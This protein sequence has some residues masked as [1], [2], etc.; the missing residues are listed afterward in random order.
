MQRL[1]NMSI[2]QTLSES[3][4]NSTVY[5]STIAFHS[6]QKDQFHHPLKETPTLWSLLMHSH[7]M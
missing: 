7:I 6:T 4:T 3:K 1:Y 5:I 2:E